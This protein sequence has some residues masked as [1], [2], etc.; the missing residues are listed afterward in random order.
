M[1]WYLPCD[2]EPR[3]APHMLSKQITWEWVLHRAQ[4]FLDVPTRENTNGQLGKGSPDTPSNAHTSLASGPQS[5]TTPAPPERVVGTEGRDAR[6]MPRQ[7]PCSNNHVATIP[8]SRY[9]Y[10]RC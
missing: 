7:L 10:S 3:R 5:I 9:R 4:M 6:K 8:T 1:S 2:Q